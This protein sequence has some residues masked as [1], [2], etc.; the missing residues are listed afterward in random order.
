MKSKYDN[1]VY[2]KSIQ[3]HINE[4]VFKK[5]E[6]SKE[7]NITFGEELLKVIYTSKALMAE[8]MGD[9]L[10][11][12]R[13]YFNLL[14][15]SEI[16]DD[17]DKLRYTNRICICKGIMDSSL[18]STECH[19]FDQTVRKAVTVAN[20][21]MEKGY[22]LD[23]REFHNGEYAFYVV[24]PKD[25]SE[26][27]QES[28]ASRLQKVAEVAV[29][30]MPNRA[31]IRPSQV[32][33]LAIQM[34]MTDVTGMIEIGT[35]DANKFSKYIT[36]KN[37]YVEF[38]EEVEGVLESINRRIPDGYIADIEGS[39][40]NGS[41]VIKEGLFN[42]W[43]KKPEPKKEITKPKA[44]EQPKFL[45]KDD[46]YDEIKTLLS[47]CSTH[48]SNDYLRVEPDT[49][50]VIELS[51][52]EKHKSLHIGEVCIA[53]EEDWEDSK[54]E[55]YVEINKDMEELF[56]KNI[57]KLKFKTIIPVLEGYTFWKQDLYV[58]PKSGK[59]MDLVTPNT[60]QEQSILDEGMFGFGKNKSSK[61]EVIDTYYSDMKSLAKTLIA[62][63]ENMP[64]VDKS[65]HGD[66]MHDFDDDK[67]NKKYK[68]I[69]LCYLDTDDLE[70]EE[71]FDYADKFVKTKLDKMNKE[72]EGPFKIDVG[73]DGDEGVIT[74]YFSP[75]S[76]K[77]ESVE[78]GFVKDAMDKTKEVFNKF[79]DKVKDKFTKEG[80]RRSIEK[81][82]FEATYKSDMVSLAKHLRSMLPEQNKI[83]EEV[84][85]SDVASVSSNKNISFGKYD[86]RE[87][88]KDH[89]E[90]SFEDFTDYLYKLIDKCYSI[91]DV[92]EGPYEI[93]VHGAKVDGLIVLMFKPYVEFTEVE[94]SQLVKES[95]LK[96]L[97]NT[98]KSY[99]KNRKEAKKRKK[100]EAKGPRVV[101]PQEEFKE[102]YL[103]DL[104]ANAKK[105]YNTLPK[106]GYLRK[107]QFIDE[108]MKEAEQDRFVDFG[109]YDITEYSETFR[110]EEVMKKFYQE[111][112]KKVE[113]MNSQVT[114][115]YT[116]VWDGDWDDGSLMIQFDTTKIEPEK[117]HEESFF[118]DTPEI[119]KDIYDFTGFI[120]ATTD[121][122]QGKDCAGTE[123]RT[124]LNRFFDDATCTSVLVTNNTD[125]TFFGVYVQPFVSIGMIDS[126]IY[127]NNDEI[128]TIK[129]YRVEI[130]SK[131]LNLAGPLTIDEI[132]A[133][134]IN[135][136]AGVL[137]SN[138][139]LV[140]ISNA[141]QIAQA[142]LFTEVPISTS[143]S[144]LAPVH[145]FAICRSIR[146]LTSIFTVK[147]EEFISDEMAVKYG[148]NASLESAFNKL[149]SSS[150]I[151]ID[152]S[153]PCTLI[154][155]AC[156]VADEIT[157]KQRGVLNM[158]DDAL[159]TS[160]SE[161]EK[162][163][164]LDLV[165]TIKRQN[166]FVTESFG[167]SRRQL[168]TENFFKKVKLK[169]LRAIEDDLY[170]YKVR[171]TNIET[172]NDAL[173][174]LR[175]INYRINMLEDYMVSKSVSGYDKERCQELIS[176]FK[177]LREELMQKPAYKN[178]YIGLFVDAPVHRGQ[179][180]F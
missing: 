61:P 83:E 146:E 28:A 96:E 7:P 152:G 56:K 90:A 40:E 80:K 24:T 132:T 125:G 16:A 110:D 141:Y 115:P 47:A 70:Q 105:L 20:K 167:E 25:M 131:L 98:T 12:Y 143:T 129:E 51:F 66:I 160:G 2:D 9:V 57:S 178:R 120:L 17:Y 49:K 26:Y 168:L 64:E 114:G 126:I 134:I 84:F 53:E 172:E 116:V 10:G 154:K 165:E 93:E 23:V 76:I 139:P 67:T 147:D 135:D 130:D 100:E 156:T 5:K 74:L 176:K 157:N 128:E 44:E 171:S 104:L 88:S 149:R 111:V 14:K 101:V 11:R 8:V 63:L 60:V 85:N 159:S 81:K 179:L 102:K 59:I 91:P 36:D 71:V 136:V 144:Y 145:R 166:R 153:C 1:I 52:D 15:V 39:W 94:E 103:D 175:G 41:I 19:A 117:V 119:S 38:A 79:K 122:I 137:G 30:T 89:P 68:R 43:K 109:T 158:I 164:F 170:E 48:M 124:E 46:V 6:K 18:S 163:E 151:M 162:E 37:I 62:K 22:K 150:Y 113:Q 21:K 106:E 69:D 121:M 142:N 148:Y 75:S 108:R 133:V 177:S 55:Y 97:I 161:L 32:E 86:F 140:Q 107:A 169:G 45:L 54:G 65:W 99:Y 82:E 138:K 173:I 77:K 92:K 13:K 34:E 58:K 87:Y 72:I 95:L 180:I 3:A 112:D 27:I 33:E 78:E 50:K 174:A 155:W 118:E 31:Y 73:G 123:L 127:N 35:Y 4:G 42:F 29:A